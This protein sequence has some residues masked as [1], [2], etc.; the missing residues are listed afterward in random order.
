MEQQERLP[1]SSRPKW[2]VPT[3]FKW[4]SIMLLVLAFVLVCIGLWLEYQGRALV[5]ASDGMVEIDF[6]WESFSVDIIYLL[7][8]VI[9]LWL[10]ALVADR[11]DQLVWLS[12][13]REDQ[14]AILQK[15]GGAE[16]SNS[17]GSVG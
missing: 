1:L 5:E 16:K 7:P 4:A 17:E 8:S 9:L 10:V 2:I 14:D 13:S 11:V 6:F 12:A 3:L 15:R